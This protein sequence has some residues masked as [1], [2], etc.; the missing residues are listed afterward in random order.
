ML[1]TPDGK[2]IWK[3][4]PGL[5]PPGAMTSQPVA[6]VEPRAASTLAGAA[7]G[8]GNAGRTPPAPD[9]RVARI[10]ALDAAL[11][12]PIPLRYPNGV[13]IRS[14]VAAVKQAVPGPGGSV[15]PIYVDPQ[16]LQDADK[17]VDSTI[18]IDLEGPPL[19]VTLRR[20]LKQLGL[21]YCN[22]EGLLFISETQMARDE[23]NRPG[24]VPTDGKP[25]S[26]A[27]VDALEKPIPLRFPMIL[28]SEPSSPISRRP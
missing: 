8:G 2:T 23:T 19:N 4:P 9:P 21:D 12:R 3:G 16:G 13:T 28:R 26:Q 22:K 14:L 25:A 10:A 1:K 15:I 7:P 17:T 18:T 6:S 20:A 27:V 5:V 11:A 24:R